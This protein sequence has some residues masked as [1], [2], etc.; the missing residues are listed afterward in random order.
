[1]FRTRH[2]IIQVNFTQIVYAGFI[3][4][5]PKTILNLF[6]IVLKRENTKLVQPSYYRFCVG[7]L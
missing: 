2:F 5:L 6:S 7:N 1:M 3:F 4:T